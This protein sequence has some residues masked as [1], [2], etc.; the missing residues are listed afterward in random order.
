MYYRLNVIPIHIPPLRER[1]EDLPQLLAS[2]I[3][4]FSG[5]ITGISE[6]A[7]KMLQGYSWPGNVRELK[8][9]LRRLD[10]IGVKGEIEVT[11]L[12]AP[13]N[14]TATKE[15]YIAIERLP[16]KRAMEEFEKEYIQQILHETGEISSA[17][18]MLGVSKNVIQRKIKS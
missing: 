8:N 18:K 2:L 14:P 13:Y 1:L 12:P 11:D 7:L 9:L 16:L 5:N 4:E 3:K 6:E 10:A 15:E 17:A